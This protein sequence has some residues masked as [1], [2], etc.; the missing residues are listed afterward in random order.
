MII[1][2]LLCCKEGGI[3]MDKIL[4][5][6]IFETMDPLDKPISPTHNKPKLYVWKFTVSTFIQ[7]ELGVESGNFFGLVIARDPNQAI[8]L[9]SNDLRT[10]HYFPLA[11]K[12][13]D[14][15]EA[16]QQKAKK[17]SRRYPRSLYD[18][19]FIRIDPSDIVACEITEIH[20][21]LEPGPVLY[22]TSDSLNF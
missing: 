4:L 14:Y 9:V 2:N 11:N 1:K 12:I 5:Q 19:K 3:Y 16:A 18:P 6:K 10:S 7:E 8:E 15:N 22:L 20:K 21:A 17:H 13:R